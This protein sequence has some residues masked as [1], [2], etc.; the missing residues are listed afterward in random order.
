MF[1]V[2]V[3][4]VA[5]VVLITALIMILLFYLRGTEDKLKM[6]DFDNQLNH[7]GSYRE[8]CRQRYDAK[9]SER[10]LSS[11]GDAPK[12]SILIKMNVC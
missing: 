1:I 5:V 9:S 8:L 11:N 6:L 2:V 10:L 3:V 7:N 12:V 4:V